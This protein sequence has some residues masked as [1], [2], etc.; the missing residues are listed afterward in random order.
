MDT[1]HLSNW[2]KNSN[3]MSILF[4][5]IFKEL[6]I[7]HIIKITSLHITS[8]NSGLS[9]TVAPDSKNMLG[10]DCCETDEHWDGSVHLLLLAAR[11]T[12]QEYLDFCRYDLIFGHTVQG[13]LHV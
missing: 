6:R 8:W 12:I 5:Q 10:T 13:P 9:G 11:E 1:L 3:L 2:T 4:K 7:K